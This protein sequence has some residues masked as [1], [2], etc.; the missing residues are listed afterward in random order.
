MRGAERSSAG[1]SLGSWA[2]ELCLGKETAG[3]IFD[4]R[5]KINFFI[6]QKFIR[7]HN[8]SAKN[9]FSQGKTSVF[10][11]PCLESEEYKRS[12]LRPSHHGG[13][14]VKGVLEVALQSLDCSV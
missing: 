1:S 8:G 9:C 2:Q 4:N 5:I 7:Q 6:F 12:L 13:T 3:K 10:P 14:C 11:R